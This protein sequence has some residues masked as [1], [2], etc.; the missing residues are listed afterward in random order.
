MDP[1]SAIAGAVNG[2]IG[3]ITNLI[4]IKKQGKVNLA[5]IEAQTN[6]QIELWANDPNLAAV[7]ANGFELSG[8]VSP[9]CEQNGITADAIANMSNQKSNQQTKTIGVVVVGLFL[10]GA[11]FIGS[12]LLN[13]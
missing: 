13:D 6:S 10:L 8:Q 2:I 9:I 7:C 3:S 1:I 12:K 11:L 5:L 4:G